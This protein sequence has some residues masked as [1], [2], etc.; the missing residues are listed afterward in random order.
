MSGAGQGANGS[1]KYKLSICIPTYNRSGYLRRCLDLVIPQLQEFRD[2]IEL[3]I[4]DNCS[5]DDTKQVV[6]EF[7]LLYPIRY[8]KNDQNYGINHNILFIAQSRADGEFC[9]I[10]GDDD[11]IRDGTIRNLMRVLDGNP[12]IDF[13][14]INFLIEVIDE[15][16]KKLAFE[17]KFANAQ[18]REYFGSKDLVEG[19]KEFDRIIADDMFSLTAIYSSVFRMS[20]CRPSALSFKISDEFSNLNSTLTITIVFIDTMHGRMGY[21]TGVP[22]LVCGTKSSWSKFFFAAMMRLGDL[23][24]YEEEKG[25]SHQ[26]AEKQRKL[27]VHNYGMFLLAIY[28]ANKLKGRSP[29]YMDEFRPIRTLLRYCTYPGFYIGGQKFL[30]QYFGPMF[31]GK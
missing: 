15:E 28:F 31:K 29:P 9:W 19:K 2:R 6:D 24:D 10:L 13:I 27:Y 5:T 12:D 3:V 18:A 23:Y 22:W 7:A 1:Y 11:R 4:S 25:I 16:S 26:L 8:F 14:F 20:I 21:N 17:G 30:R